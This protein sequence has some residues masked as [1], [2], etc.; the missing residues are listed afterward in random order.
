MTIS[1]WL[2]VALL[3]VCIISFVGWACN[4]HWRETLVII[5]FIAGM[6]LSGILIAG[7]LTL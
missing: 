4:L 6:L 2:G 3:F 1:Q 5:L 7:K